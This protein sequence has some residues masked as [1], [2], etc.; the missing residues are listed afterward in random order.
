MPIG[1]SKE[2]VTLNQFIERR[3]N[4]Y[5]RCVEDSNEPIMITDRAGRLI[6]VNP[7]WT[8]I[9]GYSREE[10]QGRTPRL[11]RSPQQTDEFYAQMWTQ[12]LDPKI[13]YWRGRLINLSKEGHEISVLLTITPYKAE[14]GEILGYMGVALDLTEQMR[15][16]SQLVQQEKLATIGELTSGLAHE[17]GTPVGVIRGRAEMLSMEEGLPETVAKTLEI[18]IRQSDRISNLINTLLRFSR[19]NVADQDLT[20]VRLKTVTQEVSSLL[21][22]KVR[23]KNIELHIDIPDSTFVLAEAN[24]LEQIL[25]NLILNALHAIDSAT[26]KGKPGPHAVRLYA[27]TAKGYL[28]IV[29]EDTGIGVPAE[30]RARIFQPFFTTK[31]AGEGT[32]L[33]LSIVTRLAHEMN[34]E[35]DL[36]S[37]YQDGARFILKLKSP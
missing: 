13:G 30:L 34:G 1:Q 4:I 25:L 3:D 23:K 10:A 20:S 35:I 7:A 21:A 14:S 2:S 26:A 27:M 32:G 11:L 31:P 22:E 24:K 17:V 16:E 28:S 37:K 29:V 18:I 15:L 6:Y 36:D 8:K 12:I 19:K 33:G 9:Y 5:F